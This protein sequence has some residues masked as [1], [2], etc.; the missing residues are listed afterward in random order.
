VKICFKNIN[1]NIKPSKHLGTFFS[2]KNTL[3]LVLIRLFQK[4]PLSQKLV[5]QLPTC[6]ATVSMKRLSRLSTDYSDPWRAPVAVI[7]K[8]RMLFN[9]LLPLGCSGEIVKTGRKLT[10][11]AD[12]TVRLR[13]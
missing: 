10:P 13:I 11:A 7:T 4:A 5:Q 2:F 8:L 12:N 6:S 3:N 1:L 9:T